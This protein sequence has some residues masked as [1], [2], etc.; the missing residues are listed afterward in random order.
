[1][2][3]LRVRTYL[4]GMKLRHWNQFDWLLLVGAAHEAEVVGVEARRLVADVAS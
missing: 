1:M 4:P 2:L 3:K